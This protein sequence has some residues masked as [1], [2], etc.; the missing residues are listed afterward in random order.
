MMTDRYLELANA[1]LTKS[2]FD[3]LGLP[4]PVRLKREDNAHSHQLAG[5]VLLGSSQGADFSGE[6]TSILSSTPVVMVN[7]GGEDKANLVFDASGISSVH[8]SIQLYEF[9]NQN[10]KSLV[11]CGRVIILGHRP[12]SLSNTT[13]A[14]LQRGLVG[15][16]KSVAKEIGRKGATANL[17]YVDKGGKTAIEAPLRFLL[18]AGS[19]FMNAQ[20]LTVGKPVADGAGDWIRPLEGKIALV[21]G[22]ARGIGLAISQVLAR[23]GATLIGVDVPQAEAELKAAMDSI[24]GLCLPLDITSDGAAEILVNFCREQSS[25]LHS[26]IHNAGITRDKMLSRMT[27]MQWDLLMQVNLGAAQRINDA[28]MATELLDNGGKIIGVASISGIAGNV[29]QTNYGFSKSAVIGM[30]DSL[31]K[32]CAKRGIT[33]NAVAPGFIETQMTAAIPFMTRQMGRRLSSLSQ[34]GLPVDVA[35]VIGFFV[36]PQAAG[37]NGNTVRVCG[38]SLLGA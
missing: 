36:S 19:A 30:V 22:A 3:G 8:E 37:I 17:I 27:N 29:G 10:L 28:L 9:F 7:A 2:L 4:T 35:E 6:L 34:G 12:E 13:H 25:S 26:I 5:N 21:T 38:Q 32:P 23:D 1:N 14:T 33:I 15:F 24:G 11:Q 31:A 16:V 20:I 18:S